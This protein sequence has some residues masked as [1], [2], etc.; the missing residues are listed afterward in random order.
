[1][2]LF[3]LFIKILTSILKAKQGFWVKVCLKKKN[4]FNFRDLVGELE[5]FFF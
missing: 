3:L 4:Y 2:V 5:L 1:M